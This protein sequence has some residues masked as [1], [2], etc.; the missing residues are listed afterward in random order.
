MNGPIPCP[1]PL[2]LVP[3]PARLRRR[4]ATGLL[5]LLALPLLHA[6]ANISIRSSKKLRLA[7]PEFALTSGDPAAASLERAFHD[8]LHYDLDQSG[9][10]AMVSPSTYPLESPANPAA[11]DQA[12]VAGWANPPTS[13]E[14]LVFGN[15]RVNGNVLQVEG[16]L[17]DVTQPS[18][19]FLLG[20]RYADQPTEAA[21]RVMAHQFADAIIE[22]LGGGPGIASSRIV[23]ISNRSGSKEVWGMDY[24]GAN[25]QQITTLASIAYSPRL[26]PDG[27][28]L[29]FISYV[30]G[31]PQIKIYDLLTRHYLPFPEF[32]GTNITPAWSPDGRKL[33]FASSMSGDMELYVIDA[34]GGTPRRL[35][36]SKGNDL[37]PVWNPKTGAQIAFV[38]DRTGSPQIYVMDA[39]GTNQQR[40]T[41]GGYAVS[42][43]WSPNGQL[44]AFSWRRMG[45]GEN[46]GEFDI[47][48][49]E[50]A[51]RNIEQ[52][53]HN[54][55]RNDYPS[56]APDGRHVVFQS[57]SPS[58]PQLFTV[59]ADGSNPTRLTNTAANEMPNWSFH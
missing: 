13:A 20:K 41:T 37:A 28:K 25:Q 55:L 26:S 8:V 59:T 7:L 53:T 34:T 52:L 58:R 23:F 50:L 9:L 46:S 6:Q 36:F 57:G 54:G 15:L 24:D 33:A 51:S 42:P 49:M 44:L 19:A 1:P 47:Y 38:S 12:K 3:T 43:S 29:A 40:L 31:T 16:Y 17:Y 48:F 18:A 56:W 35:T 32:A 45:G 22:K 11:L 2:P 30:S 14:R 4:M 27:T 10:V 21:A 5:F 39:D